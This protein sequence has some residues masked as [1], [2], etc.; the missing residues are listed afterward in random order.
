V[1]AT[2][3]SNGYLDFYVDEPLNWVIEILKKERCMAKHAKK[4][5][6]STGIIYKEIT[7]YTKNIAI[8]DIRNESIKI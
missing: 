6:E 4:F 2:F 3:V 1:D 7:L 8:V 5:D